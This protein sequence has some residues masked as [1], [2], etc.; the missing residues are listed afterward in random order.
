MNKTKISLRE[1]AEGCKPEIK[2]EVRLA[3]NISDRL[4]S[5]MRQKGISKSELAKALDRRPNE[6]T[7][8]LSG[9]YN[10]TLSTI[11]MLSVFFGEPI[12]SVS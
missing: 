11:A 3:M 8:W 12:I 5:L 2:E 10:F 1:M 4:D 7:Y 6:V 9:Q